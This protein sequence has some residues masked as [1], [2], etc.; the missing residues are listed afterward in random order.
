GATDTTNGVGNLIVG[1]DEA[2]SGSDHCSNG[3]YADEASCEGAGELWDALQ[4]TG[5]HNLVIGPDHSYPQFGGLVAGE[6]NIING[7]FSSVSGGLENTA[8][9]KLSSVSGGEN[10]TASGV[11]SS[12]SGGLD[13]T[14]S[15]DSSSVSGGENNTASGFTSSVSGGADREASSDDDWVAGSLFEDN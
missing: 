8:S 14:A 9:G 11:L 12:V 2:D 13:N 10:N 5:S 3:E 1:Y 15:S 4:K 7:F 6:R